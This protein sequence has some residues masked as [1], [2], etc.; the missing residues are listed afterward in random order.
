M[1]NKTLAL[2]AKNYLTELNNTAHEYGFSPNDWTITLANEA[3]RKSIEKKYYPAVFAEVL[4]LDLSDFNSL[5]KIK[6]ENANSDVEVKLAARQSSTS[7]AYF[8]AFN[9]ERLS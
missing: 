7:S 1:A 9:P 8:C 6:Y 4:S 2:Q 3:E 5:L